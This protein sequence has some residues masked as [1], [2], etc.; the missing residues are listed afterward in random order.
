M[1]FPPFCQL[2]ANNGDTSAS[3][4]TPPTLT[5][6]ATASSH[7][8]ATPHSITAAGAADSDYTISYVPG[9]LTV[10]PVALTITADNK[11]KAYGASLPTLTAQRKIFFFNAGWDSTSD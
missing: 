5:T 7:V 2:N 6:T 3:L 1:Y 4:T 9:T 10:T 8:S 11:N